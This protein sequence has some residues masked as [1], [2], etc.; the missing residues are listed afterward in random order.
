MQFLSPGVIFEI[1]VTILKT[2]EIVQQ[3]VRGSDYLVESAPWTISGS[4]KCSKLVSSNSEVYNHCTNTSEE[5][6]CLV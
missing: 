4:C 6:R 1:I 3:N 2:H 5:G